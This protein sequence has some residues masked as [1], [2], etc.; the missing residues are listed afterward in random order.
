DRCAEI[1]LTVASQPVEDV[2]ADLA[3]AKTAKPVRPHGQ[4]VTL[5]LAM[6]RT[7]PQAGPPAVHRRGSQILLDDMAQIVLFFQCFGV[8]SMHRFT[9]IIKVSR[10]NDGATV[11][12]SGIVSPPRDTFTLPQ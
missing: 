10:K 5:T 9:L 12:Q 1:Q 6:K 4:A 2:A 8:D 7:F 3:F 11:T